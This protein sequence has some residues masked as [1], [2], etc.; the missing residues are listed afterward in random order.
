MLVLA[1]TDWATAT[2]GHPMVWVTAADSGRWYPQALSDRI[3]ALRSD[4]TGKPF[5]VS[6]PTTVSPCPCYVQGG[7]WRSGHTCARPVKD[8][9]TLCGIH[10]GAA[11]RRQA[12]AAERKA[13]TAVLDEARNRK[14]ETRRAAEETVARLADDLEALGITPRT[15]TVADDGSIR[16]PAEVLETLARFATE[17][18]EMFR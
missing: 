11:A 3:T 17:G 6:A 10:T 14:A 15:V 9:H 16:M 7:A 13:R 2:S 8:G 1:N 12:K 18:Q 4:R 5:K